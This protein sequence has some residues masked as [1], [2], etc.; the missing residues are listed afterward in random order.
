[1]HGVVAEAAGG[2]GIGLVWGWLVARPLD[3]MRW[4]GRTL[5]LL[6]GATI[7]LLVGGRPYLQ[8]ATLLWFLALT[9]VGLGLHLALRAGLRARLAGS[10][11]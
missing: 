6:L 10:A 7:L 11:P 8:A 1:M 5:P 4:P 9:V 2:V 3:A